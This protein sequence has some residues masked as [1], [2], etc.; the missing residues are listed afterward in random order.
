[1]QYQ[2][3]LKDAD[4]MRSYEIQLYIY[5]IYNYRKASMMGEVEL[6][7]WRFEKSVKYNKFIYVLLNILYE[8]RFR[9]NKEINFGH[10][11]RLYIII[12]SIV[13]FSIVHSIRLAI[14]V[15]LVILMRIIK[16]ISIVKFF[17]ILHNN[18]VI[19]LRGINI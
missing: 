8:T 17:A 2:I 5:N 13:R 7:N 12:Y 14:T 15:P 18:K 11:S 1:M 3:H 9:K 19:R 16:L 4:V 6:R 10:F